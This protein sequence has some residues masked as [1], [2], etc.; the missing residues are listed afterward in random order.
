MLMR[1][2]RKALS[3][4]DLCPCPLRG[5]PDM[6]RV[7]RPENISRLVAIAVPA[8]RSM[9]RLVDLDIVEPGEDE[10]KGLCVLPERA[11]AAPGASMN[12]APSKI[13]PSA[14]AGQDRRCW[15][16]RTCR[17]RGSLPRSRPSRQSAHR[18]VHAAHRC[19]LSRQS[20]WVDLTSPLVRST[21][22]GNFRECDWGPPEGFPGC[23]AVRR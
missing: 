6:E 11:S 21:S 4:T 19:S 16:F 5:R 8:C 12:P 10:F 22:S 23:P 1:N 14:Q 13:T 7:Q 18:Y 9:K 17:D 2:Q 3:G 20:C 15:G